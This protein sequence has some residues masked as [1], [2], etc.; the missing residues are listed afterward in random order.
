MIRVTSFGKKAIELR[1]DYIQ[2]ASRLVPFEWREIPIKNQASSRPSS[3]FPEEQKFLKN[4][5]QFFLIDQTGK[6]MSSEQFA[7]WLF[8]A[9][10]RH[11]VLGPAVGFAK[12][13]FEKAAGVISLSQLTFTHGLAHIVLA[14]SIY[15]AACTQKNHPFVK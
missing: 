5:K 13:F 10:D 7:N 11:L 15:R 9:P 14:E 6:E 8:K 4:Q 3:L 1:D 2:R 12:D